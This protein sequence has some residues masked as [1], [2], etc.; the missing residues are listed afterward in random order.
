MSGAWRSA[1]RIS[2][3]REFNHPLGVQMITSD[4]YQELQTGL[5]YPV[6]QVVVCRDDYIRVKFDI[7]FF[8]QLIGALGQHQVEL[9]LAHKRAGA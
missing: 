3:R 4:F 2:A 9:D 7:V 6:G 5:E 1:S 8:E